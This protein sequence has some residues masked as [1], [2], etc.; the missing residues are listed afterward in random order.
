LV[1]DLAV[2]LGRLDLR[3][4]LDVSPDEVVALV[5]PN[6]AGKTTLL[7][8]LAGLVPIDG[9]GAS[10]GDLVLDDVAAGVHLPPERRPVGVVFQDHLLFPHL[11]ALDNVAYGLRARGV[12]RGESRRR[13]AGWLERM[14][15]ADHASSRPSTLSGGEAQR[16][17]L[18]RAMATEPSVLLLDEPL[19]AVDAAAKPALRRRLREDLSADPCVRIV[20]THDPVDAMALADRLVVLEG[21]RVTQEGPVTEVTT[22]PRSPWVAQLVGLNLFRGVAGDGRLTLPDGSGLTVP[23]AASGPAFALVHPR[24]VTMHRRAPEGSA[25]NAWPGVAA[26]IHLVSDRV[27]VQVDGAPPIVAEVTPAAAAELRLAE[28]GPVWISVKA[29]EIDVY[30][31]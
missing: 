6:G 26:G 29:T 5:G 4:A 19:S 24:S 22:R 3:A 21:G 16:V 1:A 14:G 13:A 25:R 31:A 10:I 28:G 11:S 7:R 27:R 30:P 20:V 9:G 17:A 18:A 12:G 2:K 8:A 23:T 15:L